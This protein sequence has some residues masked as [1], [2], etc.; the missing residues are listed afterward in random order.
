M[1]HSYKNKLM[2]PIWFT[3]NNFFSKVAILIVS[4][5]IS[6]LV[7]YYVLINL[8]ELDVYNMKEYKQMLIVLPMVMFLHKG[9]LKALLK[10]IK[11]WF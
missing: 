1:L 8:L 11:D 4:L 5:I 10:N 7:I 9:D 2:F 3:G 6:S